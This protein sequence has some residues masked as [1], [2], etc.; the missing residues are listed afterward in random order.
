MSSSYL[1]NPAVF[2][3][4]TLFGLYILVVLLRFLLQ[5]FRADFYNPVSQFVVKVTTPVLNPLRRI[6]PGIGGIDVS[7]LILAWLLQALAL[8]L[9]TLVVGGGVNPIG[10]F[11]WAIP[12]LVELTINIFLFGILIQVI[13]SWVAP[14]GHNPVIGLIHTL[15]E[16]VMAPARR[17]LPPISGLDLSPMLVM[18]G[19]VLLKMLLLP[20][21]KMITVSPF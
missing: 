18:I 11:L 20:P 6:I 2:L 19:L 4:Q 9:I 16:P 3:I 21:L 7:S 15:T 10:P 14:G 13:L 5:L 8:F 1:T 12:E 17:I